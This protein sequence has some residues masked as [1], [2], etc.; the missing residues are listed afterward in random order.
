M[1]PKIGLVLGGG[2]SRGLAHIGVLE[3]LARENIPI[4]LIVGTS[5]GAIIGTLFALGLPPA[6][7][8]EYMTQWRGSNV[9]TMNLFSAR[10]RQRM[11]KD[12]LK[13][14]MHDKTFADLHI[15]VVVMAVDMLSGREVALDSGALVPAVLASSAVPGVFPP[16]EIEGM[17]LADGG[18][19]DSLCTET[20][21]THGAE[22]VI[23]VDIHPRLEQNGWSD[24]LAAI[25][26][27]EL[28]FNVLSS[29]PKSPSMVSALYRSI[30]IMTWNLHDK[31]LALY[32]PDVLLRPDVGAYGS[33]DFKDLDGPL[34][35]GRTEAE[36]YL[37][38]M[39]A[40][41]DTPRQ[42]RARA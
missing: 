14:V 30:R 21:F 7:I 29:D 2:G 34:M 40:L 13:R 24:P 39:K 18:V 22:K 25:M 27:I 6:Q 4:D 17:H 15:P 9:F 23:A 12:Q 35:A 19:V 5:M 33:L 41:L 1:R 16:V 28:P 38:L 31:R 26:G 36:N 37:L 11:V 8:R 3:V 20:A 32:P 10:A 42:T